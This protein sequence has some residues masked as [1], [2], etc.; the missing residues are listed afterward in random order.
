M[1]N[2]DGTIT[3]SGIG[4]GDMISIDGGTANTSDDDT[5]TSPK[6]KDGSH[7]VLIVEVTTGTY[8]YD[9]LPKTVTTKIELLSAPIDW[10]QENPATAVGIA[11]AL[12]LL[13]KFVLIPLYNGEPVF[14]MDDKPKISK[15]V[16][17]KKRFI[18][19]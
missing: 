15:S 7:T 5:F 2:P 10:V 13:I 11:V 4:K 19:V 17:S 14:G 9:G 12:G 8:Y 16:S 3:I 6:L 1:A 18:N